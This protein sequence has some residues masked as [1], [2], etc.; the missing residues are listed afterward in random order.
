MLCP[1]PAELVPM[2]YQTLSDLPKPVQD[3]L[4]RHAREIFLAAFNSAWD[5]YDLPEERRSG[6]SREETSYRVAWSAVKK[7]YVKDET[8]GKWIEKAESQQ[9]GLP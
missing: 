2:P 7:K 9:G 5:E 4:P 1:S 3:N 8:S 6:A